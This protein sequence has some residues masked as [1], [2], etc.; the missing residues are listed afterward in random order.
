[1]RR[2][3]CGGAAVSD[4]R[5]RE[6]IGLLS[7]A[8]V[9]WP[10]AGRAWEAETRV[11]NPLTDPCHSDILTGCDAVDQNPAWRHLCLHSFAS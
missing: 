7:G 4:M 5:R 1:M 6:L 9:A 8:A 3:E 10:L 11:I 2:T